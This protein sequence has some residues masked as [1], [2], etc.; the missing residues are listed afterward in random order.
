[1]PTISR[2]RSINSDA[3]VYK[4]TVPA[5]WIYNARWP[6]LQMAW[7]LVR[8]FMKAGTRRYIGIE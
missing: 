5:L 1:M 2:E 6:R 8:L 7:W 4:L 3:M